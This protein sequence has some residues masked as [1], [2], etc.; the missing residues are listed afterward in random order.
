MF[1][2][3]SSWMIESEERM[4]VY[5]EGRKEEIEEKLDEVLYEFVKEGKW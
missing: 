4:G 2:V 5:G 1:S 3:M